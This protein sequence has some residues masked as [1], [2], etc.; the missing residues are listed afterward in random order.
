MIDVETNPGTAVLVALFGA[1]V[2]LGFAT[3]SGTLALVIWLIIGVIALIVSYALLTR[4][5]QW[6]RGQRGGGYSGQ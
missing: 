2:L 1:F 4:L 5:A 3:L 6:A